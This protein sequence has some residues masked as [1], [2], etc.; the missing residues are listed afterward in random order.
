MQD[1]DGCYGL[2]RFD[3]RESVLALYQCIHC[4]GIPKKC[5]RCKCEAKTLC[6]GICKLA[7]HSCGRIDLKERP[8]QTTISN[9][10]KLTVFCKCNVTIKL[11]EL[12]S[13]ILTSGTGEPAANE[14]EQEGEDGTFDE[15]AAI[16][17]LLMETSMLQKDNSKRFELIEAILIVIRTALQ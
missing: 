17:E 2:K 7:C 11:S 12:R 6:C 3:T 15:P 16:A 5:F 4:G 13:H 1:T 14:T 9:I 8:D 10:E